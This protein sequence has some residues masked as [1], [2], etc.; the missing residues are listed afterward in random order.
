MSNEQRDYPAWLDEELFA[1]LTEDA[2]AEAP[3]APASAPEKADAPKTDRPPK[4][5]KAAAACGGIAAS[6]PTLLR[7]GFFFRLLKYTILFS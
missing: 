7:W 5:K 3:E 2:A 6:L 4:K 1:G